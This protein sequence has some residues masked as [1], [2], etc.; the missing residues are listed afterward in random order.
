MAKRNA[1]RCNLKARS[2]LK[3]KNFKKNTS[4]TASHPTIHFGY[5]RGSCGRCMG[6]VKKPR[7]ASWHE[8]S[9]CVMD[10]GRCLP[11]CDFCL[12]K[13]WRIQRG[14]EVFVF[15]FLFLSSTC[16][17][18]PVC[19]LPYVDLFCTC[20]IMFTPICFCF[21]LFKPFV[22][23][24]LAFVQPAAKFFSSPREW[25]LCSGNP[26][27]WRGRENHGTCSHNHAVFTV[28]HEK[29]W[30]MQIKHCEFSCSQ[31]IKLMASR[32]VFSPRF[33]VRLLPKD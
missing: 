11:W 21:L 15:V 19:W 30:S 2:D 12:W 28:R 18:K 32:A 31:L 10:Q 29:T 24:G 25:H 4:K 33:K 14:P 27:V 20:L 26:S 8:V 6:Y 17:W 23:S 13:V 16:P 3:K 22:D 5:S 1:T 9:C 7:N